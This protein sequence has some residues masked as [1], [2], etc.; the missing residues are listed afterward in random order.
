MAAMPSPYRARSGTP[1]AVLLDAMGTLVELEPPAPRLR[2]AL[3]DRLGV[4]VGLDGAQ[5]AMRAEIGYYRAHHLRGAD[6]IGLAGL[7]RECARVVREAL[8]SL[9]EAGEEEVLEGLLAAL[10][11]RAH[12]D[13]PP[14]L[15][16]LRDAGV[17]LVAASNW[18]VSLHDVLAETGLAPLLDGA[19][20]SAEVGADKPRPALFERALELA[21]GAV[22][23][24]AVHVGDRIDEDVAGA[25]AAGI[26]PVLVVRDGAASDGAA[27]GG[28]ATIRTL[29]ELPPL[30]GV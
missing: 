29:A 20:S 23:A 8:P 16:A 24:Q 27:P 2:A 26:R 25:V 6:A 4:D 15:R 21:G 3:H 7:R 1:R 30:V 18:D 17:A 22:P 12:A 9:G 5:R 28:V 13:A 10:R 19:V 11:F 14:A